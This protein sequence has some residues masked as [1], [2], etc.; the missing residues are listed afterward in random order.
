MLDSSDYI[1]YGLLVVIAVLLTVAIIVMLKRSQN[2]SGNS[3]AVPSP[4]RESVSAPTVAEPR[5][6]LQPDP[7]EWYIDHLRRVSR[8]ITQL[9]DG[10]YR[11]VMDSWSLPATVE[12]A[13]IS[14][15]YGQYDDYVPNSQF[16]FSYYEDGA[17]ALSDRGETAATLQELT[18]RFQQ[19]L[20]AVQPQLN[21]ALTTMDYS[22]VLNVHGRDYLGF[23]RSLSD[24]CSAVEMMDGLWRPLA[25]DTLGP[26]PFATKTEG[27]TV[28]FSGSGSGNRNW[29]AS[30][31]SS[32]SFSFSQG[33]LVVAFEHS[34]GTRRD[35]RQGEVHLVRDDPGFFDSKMTIC[36]FNGAHSMIGMWRVAKGMWQDP[37]PNIDYHMEVKAF[38]KW[39][40]VVF[41]PD[42]GQ[43]QDNFPHRIGMDGGAAVVGPFRT[44][45]RPIRA[46]ILHGGNSEFMLTFVSLDGTHEPDPF[47]KEGQINLEGHELALL[48]GKEYL[49]CGWGNGPWSVYL[50]E[51]F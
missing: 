34:G 47:Q 38:G 14:Q 33:A 43:S 28:E 22:G 7:V 17:W 40:C 35:D 24:I 2:A 45:A 44:G 27:Q 10:E 12:L 13:R 30:I 48:P 46:N 23:E 16:Y 42:L 20:N 11:V 9:N 32:Q 26:L 37:H 19:E 25:W 50:T 51:G 8:T 39:H 41:H 4:G 3:A 31:E 15:R 18:E 21:S 6:E 29:G 5:E 1:L 36:S 49:M